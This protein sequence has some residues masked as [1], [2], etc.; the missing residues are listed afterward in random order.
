M[1]IAIG[2]I[3]GQRRGAGGVLAIPGRRFGG[4]Q[5]SPQAYKR[6]LPFR[7]PPF[8]T[9]SLWLSGVTRDSAGAILGSCVVQL[10]RTEDDSYQ[11]QTFSDATT[12]A[13]TFQILEGGPFYIVAYKAGGPDVAGTTVNTLVG[14]QVVA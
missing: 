14:A 4:Y 7:S 1:P 8:D 10:F 3:Q 13:F 2:G 11:G 6:V 5:Y 9:S 12:G